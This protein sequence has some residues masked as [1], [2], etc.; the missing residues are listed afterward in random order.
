MNKFYKLLLLSL[1]VLMNV[2]ASRLSAQCFNVSAYGGGVAPVAGASITT[3]G[4]QFA[5]EYATITSVVAGN[6]YSSASTVG[7]DYFTV[8]SGVANGPVVAMGQTPLVWTA[9]TNGSYYIHCNT[10]SACG[11]DYSCRTTY[12]GCMGAAC[13][14][15]SSFGSALAPVYGASVTVSTCNYAGD[16]A[17]VNSVVAG[18][19]YVS[20]SSIPTDYFTI[21][22]GSSAGPVV[23]TGLSPLTW[24]AMVSGNHY[25]H[26]NSSSSCGTVAVCRSNFLANVGNLPPSNDLCSSA[27]PLTVGSV[28]VGTT[29]FS[30]LESPAPPTCVGTSTQPGVWYTVIGTGNRLGASL[31]AS[32]GWDSKIF[33]YSGICGSYTCITGNDDNGP[34]CAGAAASATWCSQVG[35]PYSILVTGKTA[36]SAF[37]IAVTQTVDVTVNSNPAAICPGGTATLSASGATSYSWA[38]NGATTSS[39]VVVNPS[40]S[41]IYTVSGNS[42]ICA[43]VRTLTVL[44]STLPVISVNSGSICAGRVFTMNPTGAVTYTFSNGSNTVSPSVPSNYTVT[45][46]NS[47][48]CASAS[49][50]ISNVNVYGLPVVSVSSTT[51]CSGAS[52]F[53]QLNGASA[54]TIVGAANPVTPSVTTAYTVFG[55]N[56]LGCVSL[57]AISTI[58][59][60]PVPAISVAAF[61]GLKIC[62]TATVSLTAFGA[63]TYTW[64]ANS[65]G[66]T[67]ALSPSVTTNYFV[68]GT[69]ANG[70]GQSFVFQVTV[71][72]IPAVSALGSSTFVCAGS[73]LTLTASGSGNYTWNPGGILANPLIATPTISTIYSVTASNSFACTKTYTYGVNVNTLTMAVSPNTV[74]CPGESVVLS[75]SGM[76]SQLWSTSSAFAQIT[77]SPTL[78]TMYSVVGIDSKGC[79][80]SGAVTVSVSP[81]PTVASF[82]DP[83]E[84]CA[85]DNAT[86]TLLGASMYSWSN[87]NSGPNFTLTTVN[88]GTLNFQVNATSALG[89]TVS[90][91]IYVVVANCLGVL[92]HEEEDEEAIVYPNPNSGLFVIELPRRGNT[93]ISLSDVSGR[94]VYSDDHAEEKINLDMSTLANGVYYLKI[95]YGNTIKTSKVIK[96]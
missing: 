36:P 38:S 83:P 22:S 24:T 79:S 72:P 46:S 96:H 5:G 58:T 52:Y 23:A 59:V 68:T 15:L 60:Y 3:T 93:K 64:N 77:V 65:T 91:N 80:H 32:S 18:N 54:Y 55:S 20:S 2:A 40:P 50:A 90:T 49:G 44:V 53:I 14:N 47:I 48:G 13:Q 45:G 29:L 33:V 41:F 70:C 35:V 56:L 74:M 61:P 19:I 28:S 4:C 73:S 69:S 25:V 9:N 21:R 6:T 92:T 11:I 51:I 75:A 27:T 82:V 26:I 76:S 57:P 71:N 62:N 34:L 85:G 87:G 30:T 78:T 17:T 88:S 89:C 1:I 84:L 31:C 43:F 66:S 81:N 7:T 42:P 63:A 16:Y 12:L 37:T 95:S 67:T 94:L 39:I 8:R 10:N 86:I